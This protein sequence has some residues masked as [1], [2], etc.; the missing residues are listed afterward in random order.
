[1]SGFDYA[2]VRTRL[3]QYETATWS[4][5]RLGVIVDEHERDTSF[6]RIG[7]K[8]RVSKN[9]CISQARRLGLP[10]RNAGEFAG[11]ASA[12]R[13]RSM[14]PRPAR[15]PRPVPPPKTPNPPK[16]TLLDRRHE[17]RSEVQA[18][19]AL[20]ALHLGLISGLTPSQCKWPIGDPKAAGFGFCG[21]P[22]AETG[23]YCACHQSAAADRSATT[24]SHRGGVERLANLALPRRSRAAF[25]QTGAWA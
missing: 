17:R 8:L 15:P 14:A 7:E 11:K 25:T 4:A 3:A 9:A 23:P 18:A 10:I 16:P 19:L 22:K 2:G 13:A 24:Q 6:R 21:R 12:A 5:A 1:M 20:P